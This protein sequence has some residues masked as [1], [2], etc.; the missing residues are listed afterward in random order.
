MQVVAAQKEKRDEE[1]KARHR[2]EDYE[3][4]CVSKNFDLETVTWEEA[5]ERLAKHSAYKALSGEEECKRYVGG[6]ESF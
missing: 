2:R 5:K 6:I 4:L 1:R 3:D